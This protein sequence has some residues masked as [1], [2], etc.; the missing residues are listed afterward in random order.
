MSV[1]AQS[2]PAAV[3]TTDFDLHRKYLVTK[4]PA[5]AAQLVDH[6]RGLAY[7]L[8]RRMSKRT[9]DREDVEQTA[10]FALFKAV[11]RF[12]PD[13]GVNFSTFA[14]RT[15]EGEIKRFFRD[16]SQ[17]IH[18]PRAMQERASYVAA[19]IDELTNI[20]HRTPS[21]QEIAQHLLLLDDEVVE[22]MEA[23]QSRNV[24]T[25]QHHDR[26][27]A[28]EETRNAVLAFEDV[29]FDRCD[30]RRALAD[31]MQRLPEKQRAVIYLRFFEDLSQTEI[32]ERLNISQMH[33]SRL[34]SR[35]CSRLRELHTEA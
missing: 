22:A 14:W 4:D 11:Q 2:S 32:G 19:G 5:V 24:G 28:E 25:I 12:D 8:A 31:A 3:F 21:M 10:L 20:L 35:A 1:V 6:Y 16:T 15:V 7:S 33:V 13:R 29:E 27:N 30:T 9:A 18:V 34:L 26:G 17:S 23:L